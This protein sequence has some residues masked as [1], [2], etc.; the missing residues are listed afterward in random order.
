MNI[1]S[2]SLTNISFENLYI[3]ERNGISRDF[4]TIHTSINKIPGI[5]SEY[6]SIYPCFSRRNARLIVKMVKLIVPFLKIKSNQNSKIYY[7]QQVSPVI[8]H[9]KSVLWIVR[10]HDIFP[11]TN[12]EWF[13]LFESTIFRRSLDTAISNGAL[14]IC[15]SIS[16]EITLQKYVKGPVKTLVTHCEV[17]EFSNLPCKICEGCLFLSKSTVETFAL[18]VGTIEPRK[19]YEQLINLW[20]LDFFSNLGASQ[21][22]IIGKYGWKSKSVAG[23]LRK[24]KKDIIWF[25]TCCDGA[26]GLFYSKAS[27]YINLSLNEGF[28]LPAYE[29]SYIFGLPTVLSEIPAHLELF[30]KSRFINLETLEYAREV[31]SVSYDY[32][33]EFENLKAKIMAAFTEVNEY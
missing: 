30:P 6:T 25:E 1:N 21:L 32:N 3:G 28:N 7:Q 12:P 23:A 2:T 17:K 22:F 33:K 31:P 20:T 19:N 24:K 10:L 5:H 8:P 9:P 26:L 14:F 27:Y 4:E 16:T 29:A 13:K 18:S 11:I 15:N